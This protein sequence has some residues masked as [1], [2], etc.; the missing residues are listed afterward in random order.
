[1][2]EQT[3]SKIQLSVIEKSL[4]SFRT[5]IERES[6]EEALTARDKKDIE[7]IKGTIKR[8]QNELTN[9]NP[10]LDR[11]DINQ[12]IATEKKR[13]GLYGI[14]EEVELEEALNM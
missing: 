1:M 6:L 14:K 13:L 4:E 7:A 2:P 12:R 11:N 9:P 10:N 3:I 5:F 8:L